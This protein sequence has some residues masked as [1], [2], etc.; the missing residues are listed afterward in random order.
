MQQDEINNWDDN[1]LYNPFAEN[2]RAKTEILIEPLYLQRR[3]EIDEID[4]T[5]EE[6]S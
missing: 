4:Y 2:E 6:D 5:F 3:A 1:L